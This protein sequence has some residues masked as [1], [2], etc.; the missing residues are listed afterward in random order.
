MEK[1]QS[2]WKDLAHGFAAG[3]LEHA[4]ENIAQRMHKWITQLK[5]RA[6]GSLLLAV[7]ITF[8]L[9]SVALYINAM[10]QNIFPWL[11]YSS[12]GILCAFVG[13]VMVKE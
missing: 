8:F 3:M 13:Y 4:G 9:N 6:V 10:T 12:V 11:G 1:K 7:G 2:S 5:R